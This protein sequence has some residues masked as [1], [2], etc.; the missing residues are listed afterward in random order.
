[1]RVLRY[2][3]VALT[4]GLGL[5]AGP[6]GA[7]IDVNFSDG[8]FQGTL[9]F[10]LGGLQGPTNVHNAC[11]GSTALPCDGNPVF[12]SLDVVNGFF[13]VR[14]DTTDPKIPPTPPA[15][16]DGQNVLA[17]NGSGQSTIDPITI[18][19]ATPDVGSLDL[20]FQLTSSTTGDATGVPVLPPDGTT[21]KRTDFKVDPFGCSNSNNC[22]DD[23]FDIDVLLADGTEI[24]IHDVP[25]FDSKGNRF[26]IQQTD[27]GDLQ[28]ILRVTVEDD[29]PL[30]G[31]L[32]EVRIGQVCVVGGECFADVPEPAS[33]ALLGS[34]LLGLGLLRR[35]TRR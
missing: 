17:I 34:G 29:S 35:R 25:Y 8:G 27:A 28:D 4:A 21:F 9:Q 10:G 15:P 26:Y 11:D 24:V 31:T 30:I 14:F 13:Y 7:V 1:M 22:A 18:T 5:S 16:V 32:K 20:R 19:K 2:G 33:L 23:K 12:G 3:A 6:A